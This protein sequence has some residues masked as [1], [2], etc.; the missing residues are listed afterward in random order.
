M[1]AIQS[2]LA[3]CDP[4]AYT[5]HGILQVRIL[6]WVVFP[7]SK[8]SSQPRDHPGLLHCRQIL[9]QLNHKESP[10][11]KKKQKTELAST[12]CV[13]SSLWNLPSRL[14]LQNAIFDPPCMFFPP[15]TVDSILKDRDV[16]LS[17]K[18][19][20]VKAMAFP[21]VMYG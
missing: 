7:F 20:L 15:V 21:V 2:C 13:Q 10:L 12:V 11:K 18:V 3:F 9:Y 4:M 1:K 14:T 16:T 19:C 5:V 6:E 17:T 8:E